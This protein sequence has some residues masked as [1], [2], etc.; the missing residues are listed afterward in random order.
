MAYRS[1]L[2]ARLSCLAIACTAMSAASRAQ[3][4]PL[5]TPALPPSSAPPN[6][7]AR[8]GAELDVRV[9]VVP[10]APPTYSFSLHDRQACV[11]PYHRKLARADGGFIDVATPATGGL[12][13]GMTGTTAANSYL[14]CT[15]AAGEQFQL[16]QDFEI[17]STDPKVKSVVL[18]L[19]TA[20]VGFVRSKGRAGAAVRRADASVIPANWDGTPLA[21]AYPCFSAR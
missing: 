9:H 3:E 11:T 2:A 21:Q 1:Q 10:P 4:S 17:T 15:G 5:T 16:I 13:V 6:G 8:H 12:T 7:H 19:D 18:T 14:G 20:L